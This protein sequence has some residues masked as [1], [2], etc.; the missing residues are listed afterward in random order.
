MKYFIVISALIILVVT[1]AVASEVKMLPL[2]FSIDD[3][4]IKNGQ[5]AYG[6]KIMSWQD[7]L[8]R[9]SSGPLFI[10]TA[11]DKKNIEIFEAHAATIVQK[12]STDF[13]EPYL[14]NMNTIRKLDPQNQ[15]TQIA[16]T[17]FSIE[18]VMAFPE[19]WAKL[20][21]IAKLTKL[22]DDK[23][24][25][26]VLMDSVFTFA[27]RKTIESSL[28][29]QKKIKLLENTVL[30]PEAVNLQST[31]KIN[32]IADF[33]SIITVFYKIDEART[34]VVSYVAVAIKKHVL[35]LGIN[36]VGMT[37]NGRSILL[38]QNPALNSESGIGAGLPK[39][40]LELFNS[41]ARGFEN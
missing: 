14:H 30:M 8:N 17:R 39:Y 27:P 3:L 7:W 22:L 28:N 34:L 35:N 41:M 12:S 15:H 2:D 9:P 21:S 11:F 23:T 16:G 19:N 1:S 6:W 31:T 5:I 36:A 4:Q 20:I 37:L 25:P 26:F 13:T 10:N 40:F 38:G 29:L 32:Q 18:T 33:I 24:T